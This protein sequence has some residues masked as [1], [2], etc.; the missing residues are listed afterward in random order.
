MLDYHTCQKSKKINTYHMI[1]LIT[2]NKIT[3]KYHNI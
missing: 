3:V 1:F 2:A